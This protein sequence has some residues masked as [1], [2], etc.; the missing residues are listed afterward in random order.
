M[1]RR[2]LI[3]DDDADLRE[4]LCTA[5]AD[6]GYEC[7]GAAN[8]AEALA[9]LRSG[10]MPQLILLDLMMPVMDGWTFREEQKK[11]P[12]LAGIPVLVLS[13]SPLTA[14]H[15]GDSLRAIRKPMD[16]DVLLSAVNETIAPE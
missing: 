1:K 5:L 7:T 14:E 13:A 11:D 10:D 3:V 2:V 4:T 6:E 16:L 8:G 9:R 15:L 12:R